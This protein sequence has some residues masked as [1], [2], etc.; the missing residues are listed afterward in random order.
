MIKLRDAT[1]TNA[2]PGAVSAQPWVQALAAAWT[3]M[4][5]KTLEFADESQ[6][7]TDIG[8]VS[9]QMLD[10]LAVQLKVEWYK[11]EY[12]LETK[13]K[14][15]QSAME[16]WR[17]TGTIHA[18]RM[19]VS[20]VFQDSEAEEWFSYGGEP[21]CFR[22]I[23]NITN[24]EDNIPSSIKEDILRTVSFVKRWSAHLDDLYFMLRHGLSI[25]HSIQTGN[26]T[27][28]FC[29]VPYCGQYPNGIGIRNADRTA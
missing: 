15:I 2:L 6:I 1:L 19:V 10:I 21:G 14:L 13:R 28:P 18:V 16:V 27:A 25:S 12:P 22:I 29:G 4:Q 8:E 24:I 11:T 5:R 9:E 23:L 20:A 3:T 7:F 26:S 17:T